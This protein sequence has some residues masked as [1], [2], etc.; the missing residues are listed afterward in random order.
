MI[1]QPSPP[2]GDALRDHWVSRTPLAIQ[3]Y[4]R[5]MRLDRPIG[6]WL[7]AIPCYWG[8]GLAS[9]TDQRM[10]PNIW[11]LVLFTLGAIF[12][13]GAGCIW[14]DYLDREIDAQVER[15][16]ARPL[17]SG[18]V[19]IR[20]TFLLMIALMLAGLVVLMQFNGFTVI[21]G[22]VSI[23]LVA[24]YP[25]IKRFSD[26]PQVVLGLAF[27]WGVLLG[28]TA[29]FGI[30]SVAPLLLYA[31]AICWTIGYD[32]I[33]ALQD[34]D[35]DIMIG[36][37]STAHRFG[38]NTKIFVTCCYALSIAL[39]GSAI[40]MANGG[41]AAFA[42]L[43]IFALM[44]GRQIYDLRIDS[45]KTALDAFRSNKW[46]GLI[47]FLAIVLDGVVRFGGLNFLR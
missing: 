45:S 40:E 23:A 6:I 7:L 37:G 30:L 31:A 9:L 2:P 21:M 26:F 15:T 17:A 1:I 25:Y 46:A 28:W 13:R 18:Q 27:S 4:L 38:A 10:L 3:P 8:V 20:E 42:G 29:H 12:M 41:V 36:I 35:D 5:L 34:L 32:T 16:A 33:Y 11:H 43:V 22:F 47:L 44:L 19:S 14:N 39:A 24:I